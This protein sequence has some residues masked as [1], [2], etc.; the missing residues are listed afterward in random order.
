[1]AK[2]KVA[3]I[4]NIVF[5]GHGSAGKTTLVDQDSEHHRRGHAPGQ[6]RRRHQHLRLRRRRKAPQVH[7]SK[8]ALVHFD[9]AGK[10]FNVIDTPGYPDFIGQTIGAMRGVDTAVIVINAHSRHRSQHAPRVSRGRQGGPGPDDRHQQDGHRQHRLSRAARATFRNCSARPACCSTCRSGTG[11]DFKGVVSTLKPPADA[12]GALIDPAEINESLIESIIEVDEAVTGAVLRR[13][14]RRPTRRLDRLIVEAVAQGTLI[15]IVCVSAKT[16]V[17][18]TE[19]LDALAICAPAARQGRPQSHERRRRGS[20]SQGRSR[21]AAGG[22]GVQD[23]HRSVRAE[24]QLHP[25]LLAA[26]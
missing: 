3:D 6:R 23:P 1:M 2:Y 13:H 16:G 4:R 18:L 14:S 10:H 25:H 8:S 17:G 5:C 24:A 7:R 15:P 21:R 22:A 11:H 26:R 12:T 20:R 9:H 19:L